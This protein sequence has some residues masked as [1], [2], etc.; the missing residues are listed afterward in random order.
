LMQHFCLLQ[1]D[2]EAEGSC[3]FSKTVDNVLQGLLRM[4]DEGAV[5]CMKAR[6]D[7]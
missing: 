6:W 5:I 2:G 4:G 3:C 7:K 1:A